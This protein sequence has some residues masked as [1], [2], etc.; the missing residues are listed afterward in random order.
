[1][2]MDVYERSRNKDLRIVRNDE[3]WR[4]KSERERGKKKINVLF[5]TSRLEK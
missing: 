1:M 5:L 4:T 2:D 3:K